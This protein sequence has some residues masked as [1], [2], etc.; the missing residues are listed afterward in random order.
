MKFN[1]TETDKQ[2]P[3]AVTYEVNGFVLYKQDADDIDGIMLGKYWDKPSI[4]K[5]IKENGLKNV[6]YYGLAVEKIL[7]S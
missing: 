4:R 1:F 5:T 3:F 2:G 6:T 7:N